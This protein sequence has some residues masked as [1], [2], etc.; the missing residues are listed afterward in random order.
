MKKIGIIGSGVVAKTLG[1]GFIKHGYEVMLG[2]SDAGKLADWKNNSG[3]SVG[4]FA[5]AAAF[6]ELLVLAV[7]GA[8]AESALNR[9]GLQNLAGKTI[10]DAT[11]PI[12]EKS[13]PEKGVLKFF[14]DYN[15]SLMEQ[16]QN[17]ASDAHFVKAFS[18][19][20]SALMVDPKLQG[21]PPSMFICGNNDA[22]KQEATELL[23][24]I[25][26]E[27]E[28]MGAAEAARAIEPL[29]I[30][31]CIPGFLKNQWMHAFKLLRV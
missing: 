9:A 25:G 26:W 13:A 5:E 7:K 8:H 16:L 24:K 3:G 30:L 12:D 2:T 21:G 29:C 4:T 23:Q 10:L 19:V 14:T 17:V 15:S 20:G 1:S 27:V 28:D 6:G 31:W 22:A 11:N 18:C